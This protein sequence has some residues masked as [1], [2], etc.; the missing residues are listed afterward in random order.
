MGLGI[1]SV[2]NLAFSIIKLKCNA[3]GPE[4]LLCWYGLSDLNEILLF[5]NPCLQALL[6]SC[7]I[8]GTC[9]LDILW[10]VHQET[11]EIILHVVY[12][13]NVS[14]SLQLLSFFIMSFCKSYDLY[15]IVWFYEV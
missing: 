13:L 5:W 9:L 11:E 8:H 1:L 2:S 6:T 4:L 12:F 10:L 14:N 7:K 15:S 3:F